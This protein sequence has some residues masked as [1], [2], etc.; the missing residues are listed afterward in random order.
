MVRLLRCSRPG[1][2]SP[3]RCGADQ[4]SGADRIAWLALAL[5]V[6]S[7][8]AASAAAEPAGE[9]PR[10]AVVELYIA[11]SRDSDN[12]TADRLR[13]FSA[14]RG[15][16]ELVIR[17]VESDDSAHARFDRI[18]RAYERP[19][20]E[21]PLAYAC[22]Q[23]VPGDTGED[24]ATGLENA[25]MVE[26]FTRRGCSRCARVKTWLPGVIARYPAWRL[27]FRELSTDDAAVERLKQLVAVYRTA[28]ASVPVV[29]VCGKLV[30]GFDQ[31]TTTG[32]QIED[33]LTTWSRPCPPAAD[34]SRVRR[35][36]AVQLVRLQ[37]SGPAAE[38][39]SGESAAAAAAADVGFEL[40]LPPLPMVPLPD[41]PG[42]QTSSAE[43][44]NEAEASGIDLP[45]VGR[46][47]WTRLGM[48]LFTVL[49]GLIDGFNPCAM[50]VLIF[51][52]SILVNLRDRG[53]MVAIAGTFVFVS[54]AA[55][56]AFMAAW[57]NV[58]LL[59]GYLRP[60]QLLL[61]SLALFVGSIHVKDFFA[62]KQG[63]S[64]SIPES[65]K[66]GLYDRMRRIVSAENLP[67][68]LAGA[69]T[70]AV[71]VNIVEL[72]CTA[73]LPALYTNILTQQGLSASARYGYLLLYILAY[74]FDDAVMVAVVVATLSRRRMQEGE[75]R[76]LKLISGLVILA[77]GLVM[78]FRPEWLG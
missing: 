78:I 65:A 50:W 28:A 71:L 51:L 15:S 1:E 31:V 18:R 74:M 53:R 9:P 25:L 46:V 30:I 32:K 16:I 72:L 70:L 11:G 22:G 44:S 2:S 69:F 14:E 27:S 3:R 67:A 48:P 20:W 59:I 10:C 64:L 6:A 55:Y 37:G 8:P 75:G 24:L 63:L 17:D 40:P 36:S 47:E 61:G 68:A 26:V 54:G 73:G 38:A 12:T 39:P 29:H 5:S 56:F 35:R 60:V 52:L 13:A 45:W 42:G 4:T 76:W 49:V 43:L 19:G 41:G 34:S 33:T 7:W 57:L 62:F 21:T 77:L 66:P 23:A 58:F